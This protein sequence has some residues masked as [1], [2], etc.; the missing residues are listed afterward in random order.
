MRA[1]RR[2]TSEDS[3]VVPA[4]AYPPSARSTT[5]A[6]ACATAMAASMGGRAGAG[7]PL[8]GAVVMPVTLACSAASAGAPGG[9]RASPPARPSFRRRRLPGAGRLRRRQAL[10]CRVEG[11]ERVRAGV[12][13][14]HDVGPGAP[15]PPKLSPRWRCAGWA[16]VAPGRSQSRVAS[17]GSHGL[18]PGFA[19]RRD[20]QERTPMGLKTEVAPSRVGIPTAG[21]PP[22]AHRH[23]EIIERYRRHAPD[24]PG[25]GRLG[26]PVGQPARRLVP[27]WKGSSVRDCADPAGQDVSL[28]PESHRSVIA[29][30]RGA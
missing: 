11:S 30:R 27:A 6:S 14:P 16:P 2:H 15:A 21:F 28:G 3:S 17:A 8:Q 25:P 1:R 10:L 4:A 12:G 29:P 7:A 9:L 13:A 18:G 22:S 20:A 23:G 19:L 24:D 26:R 5:R